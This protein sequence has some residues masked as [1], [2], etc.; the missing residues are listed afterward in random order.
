MKMTRSWAP[1]FAFAALSLAACDTRKHADDKL[2]G[3]LAEKDLSSQAVGI[4]N[5]TQT[6]A[7]VQ[8][9]AGDVIRNSADCSK[10]REFAPD[11]LR[12]IA[13]ADQRVQTVTGRA[14]LEGLKKQIE[15]ALAGCPS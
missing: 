2:G 9:A 7:A 11:A 6:L 5:D 13:D 15:A 10:V 4:T 14:T 3:P 1:V 8:Q 12:A